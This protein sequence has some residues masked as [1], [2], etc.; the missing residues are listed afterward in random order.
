MQFSLPQDEVAETS[1]FTQASKPPPNYLK[2][3][4]TKN[5]IKRSNMDK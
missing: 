1:G 3:R 5:L 2:K 4:K